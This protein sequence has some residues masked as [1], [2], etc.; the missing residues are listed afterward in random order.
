MVRI[1]F[2][3][4][5]CVCAH[6]PLVALVRVDQLRPQRLGDHDRRLIAAQPPAQLLGDHVQRTGGQLGE[7]V[8]WHTTVLD[9]LQVIVVLE[10]FG[11]RLLDGDDV[12]C[13]GPLQRAEKRRAALVAAGIERLAVATAHHAIGDTWCAHPPFAFAVHVAVRRDEVDLVPEA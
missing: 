1:C 11:D 10:C 9:V 12:R 5:V 6:L 7:H 13:F 3:S 2:G 4:A 8:A